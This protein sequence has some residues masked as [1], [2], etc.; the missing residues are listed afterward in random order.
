M[1][2]EWIEAE[3]EVRKYEWKEEMEGNLS[4]N[5]KAAMHLV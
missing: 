3:I 5:H 1:D 4:H 2:T